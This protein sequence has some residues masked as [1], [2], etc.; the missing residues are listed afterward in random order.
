MTFISFTQR[1]G[2]LFIFCISIFPLHLLYFIFLFLISAIVGTAVSPV[3]RCGTAGGR[4]AGLAAV[5]CYRLSSVSPGCA[6][7]AVPIH[8][9]SSSVCA[10][11]PGFSWFLG[12]PAVNFISKF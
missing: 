12:C 3:R 11:P 9:F 5:R 7:F 2:R 6:R 1:L 10:F 4:R 8:G